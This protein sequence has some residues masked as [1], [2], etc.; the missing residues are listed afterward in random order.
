MASKHERRVVVTGIGIISP[1]GIGVDGLRKGLRSGKSAVKTITA[2]DTAPFVTH[3]AATIQDFDPAPYLEGKKL[4]RLDKFSQ[5]AVAAAKMAVL[6]AC[7]DL[8]Q[9]NRDRAG[10]CLGTALGGVGFAEILL[11]IL[12][13]LIGSVQTNLVQ[14]APEVDQATNF[15][16]AATQARNAWHKKS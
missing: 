7:L 8:E 3:I 16:V 5:F 6:D 12:R 9:E 14:H 13:E 10:V 11:V 4:K 15:G 2:F 1:I